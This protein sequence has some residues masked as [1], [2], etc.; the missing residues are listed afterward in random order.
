MPRLLAIV[1]TTVLVAGCGESKPQ[2]TPATDPET[3]KRL[4]E[5]QKQGRQGE[6]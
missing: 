3:I 2:P 6:K 4:E 1:V 5:Q